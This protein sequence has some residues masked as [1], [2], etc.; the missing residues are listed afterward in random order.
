MHVE[1]KNCQLIFNWNK[2][3]S[4][5][6][7]NRNTLPEILPYDFYS[8]NS[9]NKAK[10]SLIFDAAFPCVLSVLST[11]LMITWMKFYLAVA[12]KSVNKYF[13][14]FFHTFDLNSL[15]AWSLSVVKMDSA[16]LADSGG[17]L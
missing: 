12:H 2:K 11:W 13:L 1:E 16:L 15:S 14:T 6:H 8:A 7:P 10:A 4:K 17:L 5:N 9:L 3:E